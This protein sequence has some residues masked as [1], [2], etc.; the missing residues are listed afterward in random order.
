[1]WFAWFFRIP[2]P[3]KLNGMHKRRG[4]RRF[5]VMTGCEGETGERTVRKVSRRLLPFLFILYVIAFLDR[6]NF[7]YAALEMNSALSIPADMFGF[8][9]GIFFYR[10]P[11][12]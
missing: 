4:S 2:V 11:A 3:E 12:L 1:V 8:L 5:L 10:V 9:S 7:G 6:V